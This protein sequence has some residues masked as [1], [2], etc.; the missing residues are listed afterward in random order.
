MRSGLTSRAQAQ[1]PSG[2]A[3]TKM[4]NNFTVLNNGGSVYSGMLAGW[5]TSALAGGTGNYGPSP[6]APTTNAANLS[7]VGL[8]RGSGLKTTGLAASG[9]WG[10]V[11][12]TNVTAS[13][14]AGSNQF[15][16]FSITAS[17]GYAISF[18]S[19]SLFDYYRSPTGPT[20]RVLQ[21]Q[22]GTNSFNDITNLS[23]PSASSGASVGAIDLSGFPNLQNVG[24]N[25][26]V[27]FRIV[28][29]NG[30][31]SGTW[32]IYDKAGTTA[33]DLAVQGTVTQIISSPP[34]SPV[35]TQI[36]PGNNQFQF[37]L[38]GTTGANYVVQATTNLTTGIWF[39][40]AT[41]PAPFVFT[42]T[43]A[44]SFGQRFYRGVAP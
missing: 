25:S 28:N 23:F 38:T 20:N 12:F 5:D 39:S 14:A 43:N 26:N 42:Q 34:A 19:I 33:P 3:K 41:N 32:Y 6:F 30:G 24:A 29:F 36:S 10:A 15:I 35:L 7:V 40:L 44:N 31:S 16:S 22:I 21:Y 17:N 4:T 13:A 9:A 18:S 37:T 2:T 1:P 27:T 11:G 8:T